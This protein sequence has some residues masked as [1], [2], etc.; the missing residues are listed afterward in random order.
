MD[1]VTHMSSVV[2]SGGQTQTHCPSGWSLPLSERLAPPLEAMVIFRPHRPSGWEGCESEGSATSPGSRGRATG[3]N[4]GQG[5]RRV[6]LTSGSCPPQSCPPRG[7]APG[8]A[9]R[10]DKAPWSWC[11]A[12]RR[13]LGSWESWWLLTVDG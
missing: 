4:P 11:P 12:W 8:A 2:R 1:C 6:F 13:Q 9:S 3:D 7:P 5:P 10:L